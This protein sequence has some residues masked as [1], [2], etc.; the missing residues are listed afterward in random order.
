MTTMV[1]TTTQVFRVFIKATPEQI[2]DAI[3]KPE[4]TERYFHR[5]RVDYDLRP[6][7]RF[8]SVMA[9]DETQHAVD[10]EV[11]E[12]DPPH[13]LV[14][15]WRFLYDPELTAEGARRLTWEIEPGENGVTKL[16]VIHELDDAPKTAEATREGWSYLLSSLKSLLETGAPL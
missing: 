8:L 16:T 2:W 4:W 13:R 9:D 10:G 15:T 7:G 5:T 6:G 3:T 14:Q 1:E 11:L 12:A